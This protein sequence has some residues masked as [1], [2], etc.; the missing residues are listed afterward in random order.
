MF[1]HNLGIFPYMWMLYL[2]MPVANLQSETGWKL[3]A[4]YLMLAVFVVAYRQMYWSGDQAYHVW[5][6][7]Q[8]TIITVLSL[9]YNPFNIY[10][11]FFAGNFIGWYKSRTEFRRAYAVF[12]ITLAFP[13]GRA[14]LFLDLESIF[15]M[16]PFAVIMLIC[17]FGVR[18][19]ARRQQ[20]E[21]ELDQA[22]AQ[23]RELV[24]REERM[25]IARDLHD[26]LGHTLSL[27][28]LKSQLVERMAAVKPDRAQ[29]EAAEIQRISRA[30]LRQVRELVSDMRA[31]TV[32]E[33]IADAREMLRAAD[34]VLDVEGD[35]QLEGVSA[36][37]QNILG[38]CITEAATNIVKHSGGQRC[39]IRVQLS[40]SEV[41][42]IVE[43]DGTANPARK[44]EQE[45]EENRGRGGNGLKGMAERLSL[46]DGSLE[47]ETVPGRGTRLTV[48]VP[49]IVKDRKE[50]TA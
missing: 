42:L 19:I 14:M 30:A 34:I 21:K 38:L 6:G 17:P 11:G 18:S 29:E 49:S 24:K 43:D 31:V 48:R 1:P 2:I 41:A 50:G 32:A 23:I 27:I 39:V 15:F 25:R 37:V 4:G 40:D 12:V 26:T 10:M 3:A 9:F 46:M 44:R 7:T 16:V 13:L 8:L 33:A 28:T 5:L 35:I 20:L 47:F 22:H 36:L 45:P